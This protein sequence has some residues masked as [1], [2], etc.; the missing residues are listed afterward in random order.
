MSLLNEVTCELRRVS[1]HLM[2]EGLWQYGLDEAIRKYCTVLNVLKSCI[3]QYDALGEI[4]RFSYSFEC[5]VFRMVKEVLNL[6]IHHTDPD[7]ITVQLTDVDGI[8][9]VTIE[10][11][12]KGIKV[13]QHPIDIEAKVNLQSAMK[14][15]NGNLEL[16]ELDPNGITVYMEWE[17]ELYRQNPLAGKERSC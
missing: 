4:G 9:T 11:F 14:E 12:S 5:S 7:L 16:D 6:I 2:P 1:S 15:I 3:V 17:T 13:E 8:L 10:E